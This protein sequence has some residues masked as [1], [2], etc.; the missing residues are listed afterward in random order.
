M[1][2]NGEVSFL[3]VTDVAARGIDV[4]LLNNVVNFHFPMVPKL[5][6]HRCGRAARQGRIGFALSLV[7]PE[8]LA[9]MADVHSFLGNEVRTA[10]DPN[11]EG[12]ESNVADSDTTDYPSSPAYS[13]QT[14]TPSLIHTGLMPQDVLDEENEFLKKMLTEDDTLAG[15][16]RICENAMKQYRRTRS[17]ATREGV[18]VAK[19]LTKGALVRGIHPLIVGEDP[20]RCNQL[21][22]EKANFVRMLQTFRPAQTV[23][24]TGI[25]TGAMIMQMNAC[26]KELLVSLRS[27]Y[28]TNCAFP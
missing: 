8:E 12:A 18:K 2:R 27:F 25:G 26:V 23:F 10:Y 20:Q 3:I 6:V 7:E 19:K 28:C 24:E 16:W 21:A 1:F 14:M 13:L 17:E 11:V 15:M 5:F 9:Y 4:P 22:V